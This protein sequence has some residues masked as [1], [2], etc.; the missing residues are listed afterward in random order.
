MRNLLFILCC[1]LSFNVFSQK[2]DFGSELG[3]Y[4]TISDHQN[5]KGLDFKFRKP[6]GYN[7]MNGSSSNTV[8]LYSSGNSSYGDREIIIQVFDYETYFTEGSL[9]N[10]SNILEIFVFLFKFESLNEKII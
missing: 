6:V 4:V 5:A 10:T 1:L 7:E 8:K 9:I 2:N 3:D